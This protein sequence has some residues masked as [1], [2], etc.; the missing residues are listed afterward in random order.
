MKK[1][2]LFSMIMIAGTLVTAQKPV[3]LQVVYFHAKHRCPT[4]ISIEENTKKTLNTF[5]AAQMKEGTI[6]FLT[7]DVS[8]DNFE[9]MVLKYEAD[10]SGLYLTR[11]DG[12]KETTTD[13]TNF[14]FSYAR[15]QS[16]K[17][18]SGLKKEIEKNLK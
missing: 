15:K 6:K 14:A 9:Q 5:F 11:F 1:I 10:G 13:M 8:K 7:L 12:K 3:K 2:F 17:F 4:C 18:I 16:E